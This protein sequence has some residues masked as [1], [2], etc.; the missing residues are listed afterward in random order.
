MTRTDRTFRAKIN[1]R[2]PTSNSLNVLATW[3]LGVRKWEVGSVWGSVLAARL[4]VDEAELRS[5]AAR[6][7]RDD[8][9]LVFGAGHE[10]KVAT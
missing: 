9:L 5:V 2:S 10:L 8:V 3:E 6:L 7:H 4:N 1:S